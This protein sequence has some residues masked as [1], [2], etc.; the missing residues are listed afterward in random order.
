[1]ALTD[2]SGSARVE[3]STVVYAPDGSVEAVPVIALLDD[4]RRVAAQCGDDVVSLA[5][6]QLIGA[7]IRIDGSP[8]VFHIEALANASAH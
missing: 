4:G 1:M 3:A 5:G 8:P 6:E 2:A 7:R